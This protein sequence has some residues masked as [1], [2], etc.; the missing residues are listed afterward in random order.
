[1]ESKKFGKLIQ[2]NEEIIRDAYAKSGNQNQFRVIL[3]LG[4]Y[5]CNNKKKYNILPFSGQAGTFTSGVANSIFNKVSGEWT[6][7]IENMAKE[8]TSDHIEKI[9]RD[10]ESWL[11]FDD[12]TKKEIKA[13]LKN[14][15]KIDKLEAI[16]SLKQVKELENTLEQNKTLEQWQLDELKLRLS[17]P[18]IAIRECVQNGD[19]KYFPSVGSL[20]KTELEKCYEDYFVQS[21]YIG[22][23]YVDQEMKDIIEKISGFS[24]STDL[25]G[26]E[27][28]LISIYEDICKNIL[29]NTVQKGDNTM[30]TDVGKL[31]KKYFDTIFENNKQIVLTGA[32]GTGK[33]YFVR[34]YVKEVLEQQFNNRINISNRQQDDYIKDHMKFVQFHSSYDYTD[35][36]EGIRPVPD[37]KGGNM[38]VRMD[39]HFKEFCRHIVDNTPQ[40]NENNNSDEKYFF[41]IDEINRADLSRVFGELMFGLEEAYRGEEN[42][43]DTQYKNLPTYEIN[44]NTTPPA[45]QQIQ[46]DCFKDGFFI[47]KNLYIIGTMND[48]DRSVEAFDFALR[49]RFQW[50]EI[51]ANDEMQTSL[52][53]MLND[54]VEDETLSKEQIKSLSNNIRSMNENLS[55]D[56]NRKVFGL[57]EAFHIGAAYFKDY[58][59]QSLKD[60]FEHKIEPIIREYTRGKSPEKVNSLIED[61]KKLLLEGNFNNQENSSEQ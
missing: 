40:Q 30:N 19:K 45:A 58:G 24:C 44:V 5:A 52:E 39:G 57:S 9:K 41:I 31:N 7:D 47:P 21:Q 18:Y 38:F 50:I 27:K 15:G 1:M 4:L 13:K 3:F 49:R 61:C 8:F 32:P 43:F 55:N 12:I 26:Q 11:G 33:T 48:I 54:K 22:K 25:C 37:G 14:G 29:D 53:E 35:F 56:K 23:N 36:V 2:Q 59:V 28:Q 6:D 60:I 20:G 10:V 42:K 51:K 17:K 34:K 16:N 46:K